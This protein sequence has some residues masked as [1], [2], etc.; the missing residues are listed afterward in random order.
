M[1][2]FCLNSSEQ[3][4]LNSSTDDVSFLIENL[5][6]EARVR[7]LNE[8]SNKD[9]EA[10]SRNASSSDIIEQ[11]SPNLS[12]STSPSSTTVSSK[13]KNT[14][15][16]DVVKHDLDQT[17]SIGIVDKV[18][19]EKSK[20]VKK[21][22][23]DNL[24]I[25]NLKLKFTLETKFV[26]GK[27]VNEI[28]FQQ[29]SNNE[30][31]TTNETHKSIYSKYPNIFKYEADAADRQWLTENSIIKRKN[32]KCFILIFNEIEELFANIKLEKNANGNEQNHDKA[33]S[34]CNGISG[35]LETNAFLLK[36]LKTFNLPDPILY[37]LN[38]QYLYRK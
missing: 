13:R 3:D 33:E 28:F 26:L 11:L 22:K 31:V 20:K 32:I 21:S 24:D 25:S 37:K 18:L 23:Q 16:E 1:K 7:Y 38:R 14:L 30:N 2:N 29:L 4:A 27:N 15:D 9:S 6:D 17:P 36:K 8:I 10:N 34:N 19:K 5:V 12:T 35:R